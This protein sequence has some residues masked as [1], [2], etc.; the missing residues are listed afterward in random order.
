MRVWGSLLAG[1]AALVMAA[2]PLRAGE[3]DLEGFFDALHD[4]RNL[5]EAK[6]IEDAIAAR[7]ERSDSPTLDLVL[8]RARYAEIAGDLERAKI[9]LDQAV[10]LAPDFAETW[11]RRGLVQEKRHDYAGAIEDLTQATILEPRQFLAFEALGRLYE[12]SDAGD[13]AVIAYEAALTL[14]PWLTEA[15]AGLK[16]LGWPTRAPEDT[17]ENKPENKNGAPVAAAP[18]AKAADNVAA[19]AGT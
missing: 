1:L 3:I 7:L 10:A 5:A 15:Q 2:S 12:Q 8:D 14:D 4:A 6:R 17:R 18:A 9:L 16:R 19:K 11:R 13:E